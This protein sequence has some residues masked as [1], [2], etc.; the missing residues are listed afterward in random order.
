[1]G[2]V[3]WL[4]LRELWI[5]FRLLLLLAVYIGAGAAV[6]L[7]PAPP[8]T[9]L[10]RLAIGVAAAMV[11]G[12]AIAG[13]SLSRERVLGRAAWLATR[14]IPRGTILA[15]WFAA[16]TFVSLLGI[17]AVG[18]LGWLAASAP[19]ASLDPLAFGLTF[20]AIASGAIGLL[21]LGLLVGTLL[22][23]SAAAVVA[24][25]VGVALGALVWLGIPRFA[26]PVEAL[27]QLTQLASPISVAIQGAG[28]GLAVTAVLLLLARIV[29]E[30]VDL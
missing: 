21:A 9:T 15:G 30:R 14:S 2:V 20:A 4:A 29:I 17:V 23:P 13:W 7:L 12:A 10:V 26:I 11:A 22:R 19:G 28:A 18:V 24:A 1:M 16:L 25:A 6:A 27:A 5:T 8:S 3:T